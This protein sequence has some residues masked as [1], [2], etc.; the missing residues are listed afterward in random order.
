MAE[1][2]F[3]SEKLQQDVFN[4]IQTILKYPVL[5][6][7]CGLQC[8]GKSTKA[9]EIKD[10]LEKADSTHKTVILSSDEIRK[11]HPEIANDNNK[12]FKK[13]YADMNYFLGFGDNVIIDATNITNKARRQIFNNLHQPCAKCCWIMN[14]NYNTCL[15]RLIE[16]NKKEDSHKVPLEVLKKY[17]ESFEIPFYEEGW[18]AIYIENQIDYNLSERNMDL[19][20]K[21]CNGF[22]QKNKHHTQDLGLHM[23][24][25]GKKLEELTNKSV[26][27]QA[28]YYHDVGKLFTQTI[29]DDGNCHYYNH[30]SV[31]TYNLMCNTGLYCFNN[32]WC[33]GT[34]KTL[35]WLFYINYHMKLHNAITDKS[36][37][38]WKNILGEE[39]YN[40]LRIFEQADKWREEINE[41]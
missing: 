39:N 38:K 7:M 14:T 37:R 31:G 36:I 22:D 23:K 17:L 12:V 1:I 6:V 15:E 32:G 29:G 26:L 2:L 13:L 10:M 20:L 41:N 19:Y 21:A 25:V 35:K 33:Y 5:Y 8:S 30:D 11:E 18:D 3:D 34:S 27:I 28:G 40:D 9:K 16:R 4:F 24:T